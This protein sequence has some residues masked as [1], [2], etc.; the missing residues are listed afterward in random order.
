MTTVQDDPFESFTDF[1]GGDVRDRY[2]EIFAEKRRT[3]PVWKGDVMLGDSVRELAEAA[4]IEVPETY[5][6]FRYQDC[7]RA[8]RDMATFTSTGYD[9]TIGL[10]MGHTIL[11]MDDP[12]HR[13]HRNLVARAF[14]Q[15][16]LARWEDGLVGKVVNEMVD[17]FA[18]D[19]RADLVR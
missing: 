9:S 15:K 6:L 8:M 18:A 5:T 11:A 2:R 3:T 1:T 14:R 19:G 12:E 17:R 10:V 4:G 13:E 7:D 16:S